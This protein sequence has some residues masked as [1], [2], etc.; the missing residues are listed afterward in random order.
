MSTSFTSLI[1]DLH[2][3]RGRERRGLTFLEGVRLVEEALA[4]GIRIRGAAVSPA[5]EATPRGSG[6]KAAL[7]ARDI[8]LENLSDRELADV[9]DT[10]HPQ[11]VLAVIEPRQWTLDDVRAEL[12]R[13][14][15]VLDRVQ[16]PGN[17]GTMVRSAFALGAAGVIAL[18]GTAELTAPKVLRGSMGA[19]FH[20]PAV[21]T[22]IEAFS[23][24][25]RAS[26]QGPE[27]WLADVS[28][29]P[30]SGIKAAGAITIVIGNEGAGLD[31]ALES[32]PHRRVAIPLIGPA[33]SLNA[34]VTAGILLY[35]VSRGS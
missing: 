30:V 19:L 17:V 26:G 27:L 14:V 5:L 1:R 15:L 21:R 32:I 3:R 20:L 2:R 29:E 28:G 9:A 11:G 22:E 10:E 23:G 8:Q 33:D 31:P 12:G 13:P 24:W 4:A 7:T 25:L 16:D 34:A 35:E 6:L 18:K